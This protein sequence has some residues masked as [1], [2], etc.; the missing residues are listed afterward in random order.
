MPFLSAQGGPFL[1]VKP[2]SISQVLEQPSPSRKLPS[3]HASL[4]SMMPSPQV[5]VHALPS[6]QDG[7]AWHVAEQPSN[8]LVLPS[9]QLSAPS[10]VWSPHTVV[11]QALGSPPHLNPISMRHRES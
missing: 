1:H 8:G 10:L 6:A 5:D 11:V 3:S 2:F 9:S 7:S 4:P